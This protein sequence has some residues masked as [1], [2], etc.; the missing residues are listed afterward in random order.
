MVGDEFHY[1]Q[2]EWVFFIQNEREK[3]IDDMYLHNPTMLTLSLELN[4]SDHNC[5]ISFYDL[6][7]TEWDDW[8]LFFITSW[9]FKC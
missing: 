1:L 4:N 5:E 7:Q 2:D 9:Y 8:V 3:D 6:H